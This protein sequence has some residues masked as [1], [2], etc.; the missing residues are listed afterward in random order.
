MRFV[1]FPSRFRSFLWSKTSIVGHFP[2]VFGLVSGLKCRDVVTR[3]G[4]QTGLGAPQ[5]ESSHDSVGGS[6]VSALSQ[7]QSL[8]DWDWEGG[9]I[10]LSTS[11]MNLAFLGPFSRT[12]ALVIMLIS[13]LPPNRTL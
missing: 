1:P 12:G 5:R 4:S 10:F 9:T 7:V 6:S 3:R 8:A 11:R 2:P 13:L